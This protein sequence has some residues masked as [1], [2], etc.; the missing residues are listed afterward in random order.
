MADGGE[1]RVGDE[2]GCAVACALGEDGV[3]DGLPDGDAVGFG[4]AVLDFV[5]R[6]A[7]ERVE[8]GG[9]SRE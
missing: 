6:V 1:G 2:I 9:L 4:L 8:G 7:Q 3:G 5:E